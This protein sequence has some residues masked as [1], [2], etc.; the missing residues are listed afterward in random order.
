MLGGRQALQAYL[1][2]LSSAARDYAVDPSSPDEILMRVATLPS[3]GAVRNSGATVL[4]ADDDAVAAAVLE[5][6]LARH[7]LACHVAANG[8]A[9][10]DLAKQFRPDAV[11]L[12]V[13]M[14]G[15]DGFQVLQAIK[16]DPATAKARVLMVTGRAEET[17][18]LR[19]CVLGTDDYI[20]KP[21]KAADV[22]ERVKALLAAS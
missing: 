13:N 6:T 22:A 20:V 17:D 14:P 9:A 11:I 10:L 15:R 5:A 12:D 1:P 18:V 3:S 19:G 21:F 7:G 2:Q 16:A 8:D 4:I